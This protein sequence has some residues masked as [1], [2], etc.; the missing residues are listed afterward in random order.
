MYYLDS[1]VVDHLANNYEISLK[2]FEIAKEKFQEYYQS[3]TAGLG[4]MAF[5]TAQR[6]IVA[7]ILK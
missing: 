7:K 6:L 3:I 2:R 4:S 5:M 1:G